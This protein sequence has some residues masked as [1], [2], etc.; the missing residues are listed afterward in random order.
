MSFLEP[1]VLSAQSSHGDTG[2]EDTIILSPAA[3]SQVF[4][5]AETNSYSSM[6]GLFFGSGIVG[7]ETIYK[8]PGARADLSLSLSAY[9]DAVESEFRSGDLL[10]GALSIGRSIPITDFSNSAGLKKM[11]IYFRI[12]PGFGVAGRGIIENGRVQYFPGITTATEF[13]AIYHFT[14]RF[15]LFTNAGGRFYWF[16]G[17]DEMGLIGRPAVMVGMQFNFTGGI[18]M[19]RF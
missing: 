7:V 19:V 13:G 5:S 12:G 18:S 1:D 15:S 8:Q 10:I 17:L 6:N 11:E 9:Y 3:D 4:R 14:E 16:P 2:N